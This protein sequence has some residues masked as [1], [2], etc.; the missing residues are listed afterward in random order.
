MANSPYDPPEAK[1]EGRDPDAHRYGHS[2]TAFAGAVVAALLQQGFEG[3]V[4]VPPSEPYAWWRA[5]HAGMFAGLI[6][7]VAIYRHKRISMWLAASCGV[8]VALMMAAAPSV[9]NWILG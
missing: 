6:A 3:Y 7:A 8:V 2:L 5:L 1:V 4:F 9:W